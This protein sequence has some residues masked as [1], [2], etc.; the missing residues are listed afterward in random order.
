VYDSFTTLFLTFQEE[1]LKNLLFQNYAEL[2]KSTLRGRGKPL[3]LD[4]LL[5]AIPCKNKDRNWRNSM[6]AVIKSNRFYCSPEGYY[7]ERPSLVPK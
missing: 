1:W 7:S 4:D 2:I 6:T 5:N 3:N